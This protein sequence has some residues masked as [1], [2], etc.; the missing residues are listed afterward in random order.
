M[1]NRLLSLL[2][3]AHVRKSLMRAFE[4]SKGTP[5]GRVV[6]VLLVV[7]VLAVAWVGT[8]LP[9]LDVARSEEASGASTTTQPAGSVSEAAYRAAEQDAARGKQE[10]HAHLDPA[11]FDQVTVR[12]V[13]DGDTIA[14][15]TATG[16]HA[17]VRMVGLDTPESVAPQKERNCE[18]GV[19]ASNH[20]KEL[21][22]E[23]DTL[24]LQYDTSVTDKYD[25]PLAYIWRELPA[26]AADA[27][28]P[29]IIARGM[30]NA[31]QIIDGY[32]QAR[33]YRPDTYHD[34]LFAQWRQEALA[35]N[36]GVTHKCA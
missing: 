9:V 8:Q 34:G 26:S 4:A 22:H 3:N 5:S 27:D 15:M 2:K 11:T 30:L 12:H 28:D 10:Q 17:S 33:T 29:A 36:R 14:V 32:G 20:L 13:V 35:D 25:R 6:S 7:V 31:I 1:A 16:E 24:W 21:V 19:L 23:G 18:E